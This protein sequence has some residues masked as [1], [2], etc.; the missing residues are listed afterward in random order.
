MAARAFKRINHNTLR[1]YVFDLLQSGLGCSSAEA[2]AVAYHLVRANLT[3]HD[4]HG[5]GMLPRYFND[6][7]KG[8]LVPNVEIEVEKNEGFAVVVDGKRGFGQKVTKGACLGPSN[9]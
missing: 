2:D 3:G 8:L 5:V 7:S 9:A 6:A 4:S 1:T